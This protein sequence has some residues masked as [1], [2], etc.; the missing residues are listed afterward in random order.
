MSPAR[1]Q[2]DAQSCGAMRELRKIVHEVEVGRLGCVVQV[3]PL[4]SHLLFK[5]RSP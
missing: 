1:A 2:V 3:G 4:R 5:Q